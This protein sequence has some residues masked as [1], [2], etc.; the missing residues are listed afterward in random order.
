MSWNWL[1]LQ[2]WKK[3]KFHLNR[4]FW[5]SRSIELGRFTSK[6]GKVWKMIYCLAREVTKLK[7]NSNGLRLIIWEWLTEFIQKLTS[8]I[9]KVA[10]QKVI[11]LA[12]TE[13]HW[14]YTSPRA[15]TKLLYVYPT[16]KYGMSSETSSPL[17]CMN[18]LLELLKSLNQQTDKES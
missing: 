10:S 12:T 16:K 5:K 7:G 3:N 1:C 15:K 11:F 13:S 6:F 2:L 18:S 4:Q 17:W 9:S 14:W 8:K